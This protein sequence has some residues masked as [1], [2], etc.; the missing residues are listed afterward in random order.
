MKTLGLIG[1]TTWHST[2]EYYRLINEGIFSELGGR[3]SAKLI[4][5]SMDFEE[6]FGIQQEQGIEAARVYIL[7]R[8]SGLKLAGADA[9]VL[10]A[11]TLHLHAAVIRESL[12]LPVIHIAD[13]V[14]AEAERIDAGKLLLLGT[15]ITMR[16]DIYFSLAQARG[17]ELLLPESADM[18]R[19]NDLIYSELA[20]GD[21]NDEGR[22]F[23]LQ[24]IVDAR[25]R[26][27]EA[28]ILGCTEL[29]ILLEGID[30]GI[31]TLDTLSLHAS[32]AVHFAISN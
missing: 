18:N 23:V 19:L 8:A 17:M 26:G 4:L 9:I 30:A 15:G 31:P 20:R 27:A 2:I 10:C 29:P 22:N 24:L 16:E 3:H 7:E 12:S 21:F 11:N 25:A 5:H 28:V 32:A 6:I 1:G 14:L 13:A